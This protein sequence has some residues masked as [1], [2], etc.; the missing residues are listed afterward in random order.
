MCARAHASANILRV[1][2]SEKVKIIDRTLPTPVLV[3][4][5]SLLEV[6]VRLVQEVQEL[7]G[8]RVHAAI[9]ALGQWG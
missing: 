7:V 6:R 9:Q 5:D 8:E 3:V 1:R 2:A 4:G